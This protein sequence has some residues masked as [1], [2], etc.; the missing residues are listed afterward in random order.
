MIASGIACFGRIQTF[1]LLENRKDYRLF[2]EEY[3]AAMPHIDD[4]SSSTDAIELGKMDASS[5]V[6]TRTASSTTAV[7]EVE[8]ASFKTKD[9][10]EIL[11][12]ISIKIPS[13]KLTVLIGRVG[14][15]KSSLLKAILGEMYIASGSLVVRTQSIA[16]CDQNPWLMNKSIKDNIVTV[17][18]FNQEWYSQVTQ[19]CGLEQDFAALDAGDSTLV[20]SGGAALSGGQKQRVVSLPNHPL[21]IFPLLIISWQALARAVYARQEL[22]LLDDIFSGLD[23]TT[24]NVVFNRLLGPTGLLRQDGTTVVLATHAGK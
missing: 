24:S 10:T 17:L 2:L 18:D 21:H 15:G 12:N 6:A 16:Y 14:C 7:V 9:D 1:L 13:S 22:L 23:N 4:N 11:H 8:T 19:A 20:G 3:K 5:R